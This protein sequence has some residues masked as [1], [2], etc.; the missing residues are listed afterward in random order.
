MQSTEHTSDVFLFSIREGSEFAEVSEV[1]RG[2]VFLPIPRGASF[3]FT[4]L[5]RGL[6]FNPPYGGPSFF[7]T[8]FPKKCLKH[9]FSFFYWVLE[10]FIF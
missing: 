4:H 3:I 6:F 9:M 2:V 1:F 10:H 8:C 5:Q 7:V